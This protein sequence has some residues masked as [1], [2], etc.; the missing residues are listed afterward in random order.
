M[1]RITF[2]TSNPKLSPS[3]SLLRVHVRSLLNLQINWGR[4]IHCSSQ[5]LLT[6]QC[7]LRQY[8]VLYPL[9]VDV[10]QNQFGIHLRKHYYRYKNSAH[11]DLM[12][13]S[14]WLVQRQTWRQTL[15]R[16]FSPAWIYHEII[17]NTYLLQKKS[18]LF[19]GDGLLFC[20]VLHK[21][22]NDIF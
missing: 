1:V 7:D 8:A 14:T 20:V 22:S 15:I 3:T 5:F 4:N 19:S 12:S 16:L 18:L 9:V 17:L 2:I 10:I 6:P 21:Q 11:T 13:Y